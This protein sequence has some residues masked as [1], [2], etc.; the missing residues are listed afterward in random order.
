MCTGFRVTSRFTKRRRR[1]NSKRSQER[2]VG[3]RAS[4]SDVQ[5]LTHALV[6]D[7]QLAP[8][9]SA[10]ARIPPSA[11]REPG[12]VLPGERVFRLQL[13]NDPT[14]DEPPPKTFESSAVV[15]PPRDIPASAPVALKTAI[16]ECF[17]KP[18]EFHA[19]REEAL[20]D[21][22]C[23]STFPGWLG[24]KLRRLVHCAGVSP[25]TPQVAGAA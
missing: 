5:P 11:R 16:P 9:L 6:M 15:Q 1:R 14:A 19:S 8:L 25:R 13:A 18:W 2:F 10:P 17:L 3:S 20:Y 12:V 7:L 23:A 4:L 22:S 21:L 24:G